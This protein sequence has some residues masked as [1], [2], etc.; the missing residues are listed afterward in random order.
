MTTQKNAGVLSGAEITKLRQQEGKLKRE[1]KKAEGEVKTEL[2][3]NIEVLSTKIHKEKKINRQYWDEH[4]VKKHGKVA[5]LRESVKDFAELEKAERLLL[6]C[7]K[8][9]K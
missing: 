7:P 5:H 4:D 9:Y 1:L 3:K 2:E 8:Y 6:Q